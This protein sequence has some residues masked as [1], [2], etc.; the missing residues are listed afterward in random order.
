MAKQIKKC[1]ECGQSFTPKTFHHT[2]C[3]RKCFKTSYLRGLKVSTFP[4]F[5]CPQCKLRI[6]LNFYPKLNKRKWT[7]FECERCGYRDL[8]QRV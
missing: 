1:P 8:E 4:I 6:K 7:E 5:V 2:Y 3:K